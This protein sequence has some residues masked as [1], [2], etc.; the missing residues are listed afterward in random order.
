MT[1]PVEIHAISDSTGVTLTVCS[2]PSRSI[3]ISTG[4]PSPSSTM[5]RSWA[6][7]VTGM[8]AAATIMSPGSRIPAEADP[9]VSACTERCADTS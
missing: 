4:A 6:G 2:S 3:V 5:S 7:L 1:D 8:P 9:S